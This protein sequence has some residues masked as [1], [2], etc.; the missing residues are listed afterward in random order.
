MANEVEL[1]ENLRWVAADLHRTRRSL[2]ELESRAHEPIAIVGM[3]CRFPGGV[4]SPDDLWRTVVDGVDA[5]SPLPADRGW[6]LAAL[7]D[8]DP[9]RP[10]T[11]YTRGGGFLD[12]VDR[13]DA[14]FF[15]ISPREAVS[16]DPQQRL[17]LE[18]SWEAVERTGI[19]PAALRGSP[20][21]VFVGLA[22]GDYR[23]LAGRGAESVEGHLTTGN[24]GSVGSG[25]IAYT[26]GL[27]G[28][29]LTIDTACSSSLVAIHLAARSLRHRECTLALA[30]GATI[31]STPALLVE[32]CR[33]RVL[34]ED[35]RCRAYAASADGTGW[36]EGVG[37]L[38]LELLSE[39]E[40]NG[41][42][43][44][45]VLRGS[46]IN[47]DGASNGLT[48][49][50]GRTQQ[51]VIEAAL[52]DARLSAADVDVAEG[53]G[54]GTVLGD[55]IEAGA[56]LRTYGQGR[57]ADRP[58]LL[59][60][61]KSNIGHTQAAAGV[62]GVI[63]M[64]LAV[65][66]GLAPRTLHIDRP[67]GQ[68]DWD[69][70]AVR[71]LTENTP[72]PE[73]DR[74]RRAG[75]SAFGVS[76]TNA[77]VIVEQAP[78][79]GTE[80]DEPPAPERPLA[81]GVTPWPL[82]ARDE[83]ALRAAAAR[84]AEAAAD[85]AVDL[86]DL[87][88]TLAERTPF[89]ERAVVLGT[90]RQG[91]RAGLADLAEGRTGPAVVCGRARA[92]SGTVF[93]FPGQGT[94]W[95]GMAAGL[96]DS[97][98]VFRAAFDECA[99][100][101]GAFVDWSP[102][103]VLRGE[104]GAADLDRIDVVQPMLFAVMVSL[105]RLW[106]HFGVRPAA[107]V[108]HSQGEIAAACVVGALSLE[109]GAR[110]VALRGKAWTALSGGGA[111]ASLRLSR[112]D[113]AERTAR[114][115][116]R[117]TIAAVNGPAAVLVT[118]D[119][120]AVDELLAE[121]DADGVQT[122]RL[123]GVNAP[124][125]SPQ[126]ETMRER[127][128]TDL[129][130]V[131]PRTAAIPFFSTVTGAPI[132]T[133]EMDTAYWYRN[134]REPVLFERAVS[135]L[136][137]AGF[138]AFLEVSAHPA[139]GP[140]L[141][142]TLET[143]GVE[144][145]LLT[146]LRRLEGGPER[147]L[148]ALA[149]A[150]VAGVPVDWSG[151]TPGRRVPLPTYP[152][153]GGRYWL[154]PDA[155]APAETGTGQS[156]AE[157]RFWAAVDDADPAALAGALGPAGE[158]DGWRSILPELSAWHRA[159]GELTTVDAWRYRV[160][161][162]P[163]PPAGNAALSG[164]WLIL[165]PPGDR[166]A[167]IA[168]PLAGALTARGAEAR[169]LTVDPAR[170]PGGFE[171][172]LAESAGTGVAGVLSL[173]GA[174]E[175]RHERH[176]WL[177]TGLT[178]TAALAAALAGRGD[179]PRL[180]CLTRGAV[181]IGRSDAAPDP[182]QAQLWGL[183]RVIGLEFPAL[184][185]GLIDLPGEL[186]RRGADR[187]AW[188]LT[189]AGDE[190]Q[191]ALRGSG[192]FVRRLVPAPG[193]AADPDRTWRP[194]GTVL[195]TGGTGGL[196]AHVAR[197][198]AGGG[199][200]H[201]VLL[202]RRGPDAPGAA[203]LRDELAGLGARVTIAACDVADREAL[204]RLLD[205]AG[206]LSAVVHAAGVPQ[207]TPLA[208]TTD[209]EFAA[210]MAA[211]AA[212]ATH[213]D[214]L[215][216]G[217][218]LDAFVLFSSGAAVW[219]SARQGAYAAANAHLDAL[220]EARRERGDTA[221]SIAW[222]GWAGG[223]MVDD[224]AAASAGLLGIR[225]MPADL[226]I[227]AMDTAV[228]L[229]ETAVTVT[230]MDWPRF[231]PIYNS[232]RHRPLLDEISE[233]VRAAQARPDD[234]GA[235]APALLRELEPLTAAERRTALLALV[236]DAAAEVLGHTSSGAV[237]ANRPFKDLG[238]DS[239]TSMALRTRLASATGLR[240]PA[241][242]AFD[243]P[244]AEAVAAL[245][246]AELFG[247][248][249]AA[250]AALPAT[251]APAEDPVVITAM[252]CRFPGGADSPEDLWRLVERGADTV[253]GFP[254]DR[255]WNLGRLYDPDSGRPGT[256]YV[257]D[258]AFLTDAGGF[259]A[260][261]FGISPR[262]AQAMDPQQRLLL[263][264][265]WELFERAGIDPSSLKG[266]PTG[267][268]VG[269]A[270]HDYAALLLDSTSATD[271]Y[272]LTG[273]VG[274]VLSG[275]LSYVFGLEGPAVTVDTACSSSLVGLHLAVQSLRSG[276]CD[277]AL[278]GGVTVMSTP[279][280]FVEF[281]RQGGL[282]ADGRCKP[283]AAGADGTGWGE[284]VGLVLLE[285][286][287]DAERNGR[288]ILGV[289]RGSA[290]NQDGASNGLTA[291]N[292]LSQQRVIGAALA[293]A[294][295]SAGEVDVV[296]AHGTGT[297][298][299]DPIEA[300]AVLAT[301]G[302]D[303]ERP[304]LLGSVKSNIGHTQAA[305]GVAGVIK[306]VLALRE[307][308]VPA[309]LHLDEPS[310]HVDW[311]TGDV[312]LA[313]VNSPL[314]EVD[315]PWRAGISAFGVSGTNAHVIIERAPEPPAR[316]EERP[317]DVELPVLPFPVSGHS[318]EAL[319]EQALRIRSA[320]DGAEP[321]DAAFS[322]ATT[323]AHLEHR[324]VVFGRTAD[325]LRDGLAAVAGGASAA[326]V[327]Q[328][329]AVDGKLA[330]IFP[331][332]GTQRAG[333][334]RELHAVFPAFADAFDEVCAQFDPLLEKPLREVVFTDPERLGLTGYTQ[335]AL[336]AVEVALFRL[337]ESWGIR[338]D[339]LLGHSIGEIAAAHVAGVLSLPDAAALVAAR[340]RLMQDL[341]PGGAML[342][343][344]ATEDE[345][346]PLLTGRTAV[347]AVN[348][349]G[350]VVLSGA[351]EDI[352]EAERRLAGR[353]TSRLRVSHAFHSPLLEPMLA[354]FA[355]VCAGLRFQR[356]RL[357]IVSTVTGRAVAADEMA[358]PEYWVRQAHAT[359]R[360]ADG[361]AAAAAVS[362]EVTFLELGPGATLSA[363]VHESLGEDA[364]AVPALRKDRP[365]PETLLAALARLHARGVAVDWPAFFAGTG[366]SRIDLPTYAFQH[367]RYW[368]RAAARPG[369]AADLGLDRVDHPLLGAG[370]ELPGT[371]EFVFSGLLSAAA[372]P[373]LAEH[374]I[375]GAAL[376][377]GT[378][379]VELAVQAGQR[380]GHPLVEEL[381]L[382]APVAV[383][384][385]EGVQFR[386]T[387]AA[388]G[389][390]AGRGF[391]VHTRVGDQPWARAATGVL[392]VPAGTAGIAEDDPEAWP[393]LGAE[394]VPVAGYHERAAA[395]GYDYGPAFQGLTAVWSR[396]AEV[397]AE[398]VLPES[399]DAGGF[400]LH[401]ALLDAVLRAAAAAEDAGDAGEERPPLL[402][403]TW[404]GV[405][406]HAAGSR[407]I[408]ARILPTGPDEQSITVYGGHGQVIASID[409]LVSRVAGRTGPA[410][411]AAGQA[412]FAL[413]WEAVTPPAAPAGWAFLGGDGPV[414]PVMV[415][416]R[417]SEGGPADLAVGARRATEEALALLQDWLADDRYA[418][419]RLLL[420][421]R[422]AVAARDGEAVPDLA[423]APLWGLV[424]SARSEHPGRFALL[425]LD[426]SADLDAVLPS[427]AA[428]STAE[429]ELAVRDGELL[430]PRLAPAA[431]GEAGPVWDT[432][433]T[434]LVTGATG[435]LGALLAR[436]LVAV[437][438]A[439][440]LLLTS[441]RGPGAPGADDLV[442][443]LRAQ[444]AEVELHACDLADPAAA[445]ALLD[446]VPAEHPLR[447]VVHT[448]GAV[449]DG[450]LTG[451]TPDRLHAVLAPKVD[452]A[453]RLHE[454]TAHL[455][456]SAF[457]LYSSAA[458]VF[459]APGQAGYA[460][461]NAF[462][463][464]FSQHRAAA[465]L[466]AVSV[467]WGPW[468]VRTG[469]TAGLSEVDRRRIGRGGFLPLSAGDGLDLLGRSVGLG[470]PSVVAGRLDLAALRRRA[471]EPPAML[472][473]LVPAPRPEPRLPAGGGGTAD[474]PAGFAGLDPAERAKRLLE[475]VRD[476][477]AAV[478]G[479]PTA[480][481]VAPRKAFSD[482]GFDSLAAVE[483]RNRLATATGLRL[484]ATMV[485]DFPNPEALAA[486]LAS[487]QA[488]SA[489]APGA[490][491]LRELDRLAALLGE[492]PLDE[493]SRGPLRARLNTLLAR[494]GQ[495]DGT[496]A[497]GELESASGE[498]LMNLIDAEFGV[499][500]DDS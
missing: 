72:W 495:D 82:S 91:L 266:S 461:A 170:D 434:V 202:S 471:E 261:F 320:V 354:E 53:H 223:G 11:L 241:T 19:D 446:R 254:G 431:A 16:M 500:A 144:P 317:P 299:G 111:M 26:L 275:R 348:A 258:G 213:L 171:G 185:G 409:A 413:S 470:A 36:G 200:E 51:A 189:A 207:E 210:V 116:D 23:T 403:F 300:Q 370:V 93:V 231:A 437:H 485:F 273:S 257:R 182:A 388:P 85:P 280:A 346:R 147:F 57:P 120:Q 60:S 459:G 92:G 166:A 363:M 9:A 25:R 436:D 132:D 328:D 115:G 215:L 478:L 296:E 384:S 107:V 324:A 458:G 58:L 486:R 2:A 484:P 146:S 102:T 142:E 301:Y 362:P 158:A 333:M 55:P 271:G 307:G 404:R 381:T 290:V 441:R 332:Q 163:V 13:F 134:A 497:S 69:G 172:V 113:A 117:V 385:G 160:D 42:P 444:G 349:P 304:V 121:L 21:G 184:L 33:Q 230:D 65:R 181:S 208:E 422:G 100:A 359:V 392:A 462:L 154:E 255:G 378:V 108:G 80:A 157:R 411:A 161:W 474:R 98:P 272:A 454:L 492:L 104:P 149:E 398:A 62:A 326:G 489:P 277:L 209:E 286:L 39:A 50:N 488:A 465:G 156:R 124:G 29:A 43:V 122:R 476:E 335:P 195:I 128:F 174:D 477:A 433:G 96:Y 46:A 227:R 109:D 432:T 313:D 187:L 79:P 318:A 76:G 67:T 245:L 449:D 428:L 491:A 443:E 315:R 54:T 59:G 395:A 225:L 453:V 314:P 287:S 20:T 499:P 112:Q 44:L 356:P 110:I 452:A 343:V 188:A 340:G 221:T 75:V 86:A 344:R 196:G 267:V 274:S 380:L 125:H 38:A 352:A 238:F 203:E 7:Y 140:A 66:N 169:V 375:H 421:T 379:L 232:A 212:G 330:V 285:R 71:L 61:I 129:A 49:P 408:R 83:S 114:F 393:P 373:W 106:E 164:T 99:R 201:L 150:H 70:G 130:G 64:V 496:A 490:A 47:Q 35:G 405:R 269:G 103:A 155:A 246:L 197:R 206:P 234:T 264:T 17:L 297:V 451:L 32:M 265:S 479:H 192:A 139:L 242:L 351:A 469:M 1:R 239:L 78:E 390:A 262:E 336:F 456:L 329:V 52:A 481:A 455:D 235:D 473:A 386:I 233:A 325:D 6:D 141:Q 402:P 204:A 119:A 383:P 358:T 263:E 493:A 226:A 482:L 420:V 118:G 220:A 387:V 334:G 374:V 308:V 240:L 483:L 268:F 312:Q 448:A 276:E 430:A 244:T 371:G 27:E 337:V 355:E 399:A 361:V 418:S 438:G 37:V 194:R 424:R 177:G 278:A 153:Q 427:A 56:L 179:G 298:L 30:G 5:I 260:A 445:A 40:R 97:S 259:D 84:L 251:A 228:G 205:T 77:H 291:P 253:G 345:V 101:L 250:P 31:I 281:S 247:A 414:R 376:L 34:A 311:T 303:R 410:G 341:P 237:A 353:R 256:S 68:V 305:A 372:T 48:A 440:R 152:F 12:D 222:G 309:S 302:Q 63:K 74:P 342:A 460:A 183:G 18:T 480:E 3:A 95:A 123:T 137:D 190:D 377:P 289:V 295:L 4:S 41:H 327:C 347:A 442:A 14:A 279:A 88:R 214:A 498:E 288:Q 219:G 472:R 406:P 292:G 167:A 89:E 417:T 464:A 401:P 423:H 306:M 173:L 180:W 270:T 22:G 322:L 45:A 15:G 466:P 365:E 252:A 165:V 394:P 350:S 131:A 193:G 357:P 391:T 366:G 126:V 419:S 316:E 367:Q 186:D 415:V 198:L 339:H 211:K 229:D 494:L 133:G 429:P 475:L 175:R 127:L 412:V 323:R 382:E 397:F 199:A 321:A 468:E 90:D 138:T 416:Y 467:A 178:A 400:W 282:A 136:A 338:P 435:A 283:F 487:E 294:G 135:A 216:A 319:R 360:F 463:D 28:P 224:A 249:P 10:G 143:A 24:A 81:T 236:R 389:L 87:A 151:Q 248:E 450:L 293:N 159:D 310:P 176:P 218:P 168:G 105:A 94:Q 148:T 457:V 407:R 425:D 426:A 145:L 396:G 331:G 439:R 243:H 73:V 217:R 368:L 364:A 284:G 369:D 191:I 447:T 162:R 8:P